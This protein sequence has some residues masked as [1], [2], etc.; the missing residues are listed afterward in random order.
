MRL[1]E[2]LKCREH[3]RERKS[4][5]NNSMLILTHTGYDSIHAGGQAK[6]TTNINLYFCTKF[7]NSKFRINQSLHNYF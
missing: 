3:L 5:L 1:F 2:E 4:I 6:K 7:S